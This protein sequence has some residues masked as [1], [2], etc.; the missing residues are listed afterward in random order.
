MRTLLLL[1]ALAIAAVAAGC[2]SDDARS[3]EVRMFAASSLTDVL[4]E[5]GKRFEAANPGTRVTFNFGSSA[6]LAT[7]ITEGARADVFAPANQ[8]QMAV[9]ERA[10]EVSGARTFATNT[11]VVAVAQ[12]SDVETFGDLANPGVRLVL[13]AKDVPAGQYARESL[14]KASTPQGFGEDFATRV[15]ANVKSEEVNV[16]AALTKVQLGEAD[17]AIVYETDIR[18]LSGIRRVPIAGEFNVRAEYPIAVLKRA[19]N[20]DGAAAFLAYLL[21]AEGQALL[22]EFGFGSGD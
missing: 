18:G 8:A 2:D 16:R 19:A 1:C 11:L 3:G 21:S 5:A 20:G 6:A 13:A 15:L 12:G 4:T 9:V 17:A 7:Q 22:R 10:G 14:A